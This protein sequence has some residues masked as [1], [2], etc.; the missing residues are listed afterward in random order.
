LPATAKQLTE[1]QQA[2]YNQ[3]R[4]SADMGVWTDRMLTALVTGLKGG[5]WYSLSDKLDNIGLMHR[6]YASVKRNKGAAGVDLVTIEQFEKNL[7]HNLDLSRRSLVNGTYTPL[8]SRR[9]YIP[10]GGGKM[11]PLGI[12]CVRDRVAQNALKAVIEPIFESVFL[13]SSYGFRPGRGCAD[14]LA[15]VDGHLAEGYCCVV[16]ADIEGFFDNIDHAT[17]M[18]EISSRIADG[19]ILDMLDRCL[20][21]KVMEGLK[22]WEPDKGTPQGAV[23]SPL[24]A[25]IYMHPLDERMAAKGFRMVRYADDFVI[26]C[27]TPEEAQAA[28]A[29]VQDWAATVKLSMHPDKT[30][31]ADLRDFDDRFTFLGYEFG[32]VKRSGTVGRW[33]SAKSAKKLQ[34]RLRQMV[35]RNNGQCMR[36][37]IQRI[38]PVMRGWFGYFSRGAAAGVFAKIDGWMRMRLRSILRRRR[39][40]HGVGKGADHQRWPN[41]FFDALGYFSLEVAYRAKQLAPSG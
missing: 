13:E 28:L 34:E 5:K 29:A 25:N 11:R 23:L 1:A 40:R 15:A 32:R 19:K 9:T 7:A 31:M 35:K 37:I 20:S 8:P 27:R 30:R 17:L 38:K 4:L 26:C 10:K 21:Q 14:A 33:P 18:H 2:K 41:A 22:S 39:K 24:L 6:S 3:L 12:P 16:D 36:A